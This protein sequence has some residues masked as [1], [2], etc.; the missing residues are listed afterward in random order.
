M[1]E[2][3][4]ENDFSDFDSAVIF[5]VCSISHSVVKAC[6]KRSCERSRFGDLVDSSPGSRRSRQSLTVSSN[7]SLAS[8]SSSASGSASNVLSA[9]PKEEPILQVCKVEILDDRFSG[10]VDVQSWW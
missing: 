7:T 3:P 8:P 4:E 6:S 5:I 2:N 9:K 1:A 10:I